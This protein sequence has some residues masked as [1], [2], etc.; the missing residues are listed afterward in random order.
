[1]RGIPALDLPAIDVHSIP[2]K[3]IL[4]F[5]ALTAS[6]LAQPFQATGFKVG[7]MSHDSVIVWTRLTQHEVANGADGIMPTFVDKAG[8]TFTGDGY[9][10]PTKNMDPKE[11]RWP[12]GKGIAD[13][14]YA[15]P[16]A[17]G[18]TGLRYRPVGTE[19]WTNTS[20]LPVDPEA[21]YIRQVLLTGLQPGTRYELE[22]RARALNS[23]KIAHVER[24]HFTTAPALDVAAP[25][26]FAVTT[27]Q[28]FHDQDRDDGFQIYRT[29]LK[30]D[31]PDF[32]VHTGDIVY[33]DRMAKTLDL[34]RWHWHRTYS[35]PTNLDFHREVGSYF[36][37]DDHDTWTN[38][39]WPGQRS[40]MG[41]FTWDQGI[42]TF[43]EQVPMGENTWRTRRWGRDLQ[44]WMVEGRDFR[45]PNPDP[46]GPNKT[47]WG[48]QQFDWLRASVSESKATFRVLISPT[49]IVGPDRSGKNDNHANSG[50]T[51]EGQQ[52]R[53]FLS[54]QSNLVVVC[55]DRHWQY[56]SVDP[57]TGLREYCCGPT[58]NEHAGGWDQSNYRP[59]I[60]KFL[61]VKGGYLSGEVARAG[62]DATL[63]FRFHGVQGSVHFEDT[64]TTPA[65]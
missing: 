6:V 20:N 55:G 51:H 28:A 50:F 59:E 14:R 24:G 37:K 7:E 47:I 54:S 11:I 3:R 23:R 39:S 42:A 63:T 38:D 40:N 33:Y 35:R 52:V 44:I 57:K 13:M 65:P 30:Q 9:S 61:R 25:V 16:G 22:V 46:D 32:F 36:I 5:F 58:S 29:L 64:L 19:L 21:D 43:K 27:G 12:E 56:H 18:T 53:D 48:K 41:S 2:M 31:T 1:M 26:R 15:A 8:K 45:S 17:P 10:K 49:P 60:H 34:A 4:C 62:D